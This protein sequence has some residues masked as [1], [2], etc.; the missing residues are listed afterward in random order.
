MNLAAI[1]SAEDLLEMDSRAARWIARDALRELKAE[2]V[3]K[4]L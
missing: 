2:K 3:Q 1:E 4:R